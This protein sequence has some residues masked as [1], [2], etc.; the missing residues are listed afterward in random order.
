MDSL[1]KVKLTSQTAWETQKQLNDNFSKIETAFEE[2]VPTKTSELTNDGDGNSYQVHDGY[3]SFA[4]TSDY[5]GY[6]VLVSNTY[7]K[8]TTANKDSLDITAG[9]TIA[10]EYSPFATQAYVE[11]NGGKIDSISVNGTAQTIDAN[12]NVDIT[13]PTQASDVHALPDSTKYGA[14]L[15]V[16]GTTVTLKDQDGNTL[17]TI[18]TQD[19]D[20]GATTLSGN[21]AET[22]KAIVSASYDSATRTITFVKETFLTQHQDISG[23]LDKKPDGTNDLIV[24]NKV[25]TTYLPDQ[26]LGQLLYGGTVTGAGVATLTTNAKTKLG[27]SSDTITLTNDTTA[28]TGYSANEGLYYIASSDGNFAGLSLLVGDWLISVGSS[29][30]KI[31]NTDAVTGVKGNA[32]GS[33]RI[34]NIELDPDDFDD[35]S[36]INKFVTATE[37]STWSGKQD[38]IT[39]SNKLS[40]DLIED[41]STNKVFTATEQT[42]LSGIESGAE[43]NVQSDWNQTDSDADDYIK[44]KPTIPTDTNQKI[45]AKDSSNNDVTFGDDDTVK[46]VAGTNVQVVADGTAKTITVSATDTTYESKTASIGGTDVS[47]VTTGEKYTWNNKQD[48]IANLTFTDDDSRWGTLDAN[49]FYTLTI[50]SSYTPEKVFKNGSNGLKQEVLATANY[51]GTYIYII[52]DTK[53]SGSVSVK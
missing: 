32:E 49:G 30:K 39:S 16:S 14:T 1:D 35:T 10:Y 9:T 25:S 43:V 19:T 52:T 44:N 34:G 4:S 17:S 27:T 15:G 37:K 51:D 8:V 50:T 46:I 42:K 2:D 26:I 40:A 7:T 3:S 5:V 13:V 23:K 22:G 48:V 29:W 24:N 38:A 31:D 28:I 20:T 21:T 6:Y 12:K 33:Y 18:T 36:S 47:L 53:F 45:S 41:G 11:E